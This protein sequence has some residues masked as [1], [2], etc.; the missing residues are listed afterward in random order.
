M[1]WRLTLGWIAIL[2]MFGGAAVAHQLDGYLQAT[3]LSLALDRVSVKIDLTPGVEVAPSIVTMIT[4]NRDGRISAAEA[5]AYANHVLNE[6]V[7]EMDGRKQNLELVR[8]EFPTGQEMSAGVGT[9]RIEARTTWTL[10]PGPHSLL[11]RNNHRRD[12]GVYLVNALV[13]ASP[14]IEITAQRRDPLQREIRVGFRR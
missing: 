5:R 10:A 7:I 9:I 6:I 14:E 3:R 1:K 4:T 11:V 8:S 12:C 2:L 13:P